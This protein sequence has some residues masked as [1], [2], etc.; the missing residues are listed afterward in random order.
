[1]FVRVSRKELKECQASRRLSICTPFSI[2]IPGSIITI[3]AGFC[4]E[5]PIAGLLGRKGF[6]EHF[7]FILDPSTTPPE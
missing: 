5:L 7:K 4:Y 3:E 2:Y 6:L 1:M